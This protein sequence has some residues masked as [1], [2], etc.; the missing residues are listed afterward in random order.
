MSGCIKDS[1]LFSFSVEKGSAHFSSF[2]L[3]FLVINIVH[4]IGQPPRITVLFFSFKFI[5]L[6]GSLVDNAHVEH[7]VSANS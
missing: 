3:C 2:T 1:D 5:L 6:D 4:D 7:E